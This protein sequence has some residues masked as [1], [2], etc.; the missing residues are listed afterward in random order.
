MTQVVENLDIR[1]IFVIFVVTKQTNKT[2]IFP[3]ISKD[4]V[5]EIFCIIDDFCKEYDAEIEKNSLKAP[6]GRKHRHRKGLMSDAE[7]M[8]IL[9]FFRL[10]RYLMGISKNISKSE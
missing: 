5:T 4:K 2:K 10:R 9:V 6:D 7:V 8:S 1:E 3:M